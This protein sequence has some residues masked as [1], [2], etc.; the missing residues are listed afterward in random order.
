MTRSRSYIS[1]GTVITYVY[2]SGAECSF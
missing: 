1:I 2:A